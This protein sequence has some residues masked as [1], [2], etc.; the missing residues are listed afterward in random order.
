MRSG[1]VDGW[2]EKYYPGL[3]DQEHKANNIW[4]RDMLAMLTDTG[5]LA[6]PSLRK[7]FNKQGKEICPLHR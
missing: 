5:I 6:V 2:S 1:K 3:T 7:S 4:F